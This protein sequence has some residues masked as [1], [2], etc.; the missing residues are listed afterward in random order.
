MPI[1]KMPQTDVEACS[2]WS[3]QDV[4]MYHQL[5]F[6]FAKYQVEHR[7]TWATWSKFVGKRKF[8]PNM[9]P[10]RGIRK[11][12]SPHIRQMAFPNAICAIPKKDVMDVREMVV[13]GGVYRQR[14]ESQLMDFCPSFTD[15]LTDHVDATMKDISDKMLRFEDIFY[16]SG[17][18]HNSPYVYLPDSDAALHPAP[19]G[20]G[21]N[22]GLTGK[23]KEWIAGHLPLIG[24]GGPGN[25]NMCAIEKLVTIM[26]TDLR[27]PPFSGSSMPT[28]ENQ[29]LQGKY[30]LVGDS[31][32][33]NQFQFDP[34]LKENRAADLNIVTAGFKGSLFGKVTCLLEDFPLRY[35]ADGSLPDVQI[36]EGNENAYNYQETLM[37]PDYL[38]SMYGVAF[39]MGAPGY[40]A[41]QVGP[42]PAPFANNGMPKGFGKMFW[43]GEIIAT[44]NVSVPCMK[45]DGTIFYDTNK[46]GEKLQ[47]ISQA[48]YGLIGLQRR[49]AIPIIYKRKRG[50]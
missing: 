39:M 3:E 14:F 40:D 8:T 33:W 21:D 31:E 16:R 10:L 49:N 36:R 13:E 37:D 15:F 47:L 5:P 17:I 28:G 20:T 46:Y 48:T 29:G 26:E 38:S 34:Y 35:Q 45:E 27:I 11:E 25:I 32:M 7:K 24:A 18:F 22:D 23:S 19:M 6:Y 9:G 42:P 4:N 41:L 44:K 2:G 30:V 1:L 12:A 50:C 43:N